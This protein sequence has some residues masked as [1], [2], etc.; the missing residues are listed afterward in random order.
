MSPEEALSVAD[1]A[2]ITYAGKSLTDIQRMILRESLAGK[3]Y[4]QMEGYAPQHIKNEGKALWDLLSKALGEK[5]SKPSFRGTLE[6][7]LRF[8]QTAPQPFI[9]STYNAETWVGRED[10]IDRLLN[11]LHQHTRFVCLTGISGIGKTALAECLAVRFQN[12]DTSFH[13]VSLDI[14]GQSQDFT[15]GA[16][17]I[18]AELGEPELDPQERNAPQRLSDRLLQKLQHKP[19]W[20]QLDALERLLSKESAEFV[21]SHWLSFFQRCLNSSAFSSRLILTTQTSPTGFEEFA[22]RYPTRWHEETLQGLSASERSELFASNG[23]AIDETNRA[24]IDRIGQIYEGHPLVL[25][26]IAREMLAQPFNGNVGQYWERYGNEF[27]QVARELQSQRVNPALY[28]REL[29]KRVRQRVEKSLKRLPTD[30]LD[31]LCR[32]SVYRRPVPETF[33]LALLSDRSP[34]Q[35]QEAYRTLGDRALVEQEGIHQG[36]FLIRQHN[37]IRDIAYDLL[38]QDSATWETAERQAADQWLTYQPAPDTPNLEKVRG[39]IEAFHHLYELEDWERAS[40][41][42]TG[43][44]GV[45]QHGFDVQLLIWG[46]YKELIQI[47][48]K[49]AGKITT[50]TNGI[51]LNRLGHAYRHLGNVQKS[52]EYCQQALNFAREISDRQGEGNALGSLG[53]AYYSL[54]NYE[55]AI[56]Y[57]QQALAAAREIGNRQGEGNALGNLGSVYRNLGNY[58]QAINYQQQYL[59]ISREIGDRRGEANSL[60]SLGIAYNSLGN[61]EQAI[62]FYQQALAI[63]C[64][65]GNRQWEGGCLGN[66]GIA[67]CGLGNYE[68]AI[69]YQQQYLAISREIGDQQGKSIALVNLGCLYKDRGNYEQAIDYQQQALA[70][71]RE[72]ADRRGEGIAQENLGST[73][74]KLERYSEALELLQVALGI[75]QDIGFRSGE[76][77]AL[78]QLAEL[79]QKTG[80]ID[81]AREYCDRALALAIELGIPLVKECEELKQQLEEKDN[82]SNG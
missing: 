63:A 77:E 47:S 2:L 12:P 17:A 58:E 22:D 25:Q 14:E 74:I 39:E 28:S 82:G 19:Y 43:Q 69:N 42:Y 81:L 29:Q 20:I 27:E 76:A 53:L 51:C 6:K 45:N 59:A 5:V 44:V 24:T 49:L 11:Q 7:R 34:T 41:I 66:L 48:S 60:G 72:I 73:L 67:Y 9:P 79:H 56:S 40:E 71:A 65:I 30:A 8:A 4:E 57:Q 70:V 31:L 52:I 38:R 75:Y 37:L 64:E 1:E 54:G 62:E 15:T 32:A 21:D 3:S 50:Q 10:L 61:Y 16:A 13:R 55:R 35:Q 18:L 80:S 46:Y 33:W 78:R 36:Q 68:Q 26:V 23:I